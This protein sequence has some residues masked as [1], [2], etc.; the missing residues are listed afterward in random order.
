MRSFKLD[1]LWG[2]IDDNGFIRWA[3]ISCHINSLQ[4]DSLL[5]IRASHAI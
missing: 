3:T 1:G 4:A 2:V 5:R